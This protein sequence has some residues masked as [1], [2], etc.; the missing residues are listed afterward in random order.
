MIAEIGGRGII[1]AAV[2]AAHPQLRGIVFDRTRM[3][4]V[5][6][7]YLAAASL[8]GADRTGGRGLPGRPGPARQQ[9]CAGGRSP[10]HDDGQARVILGNLRAAAITGPGCCWPA[11]CCPITPPRTSAAT[12]TCR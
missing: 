3:L 9:L 12:W 8:T 10:Q 4:G 6:R 7:D 1:A 5:A 2:L 11:S